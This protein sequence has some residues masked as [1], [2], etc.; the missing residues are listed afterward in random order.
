MEAEE[1]PMLDAVTRKQL[2]KTE[3]TV[4][5]SAEAVVNCKL[6]RLPMALQFLVVTSHV[7]KWSINPIS[8]PKTCLQS[9]C[10]M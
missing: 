1:S 7:A 10:T 2:M 9:L 6:C 4:K 8:N 3:K 5:V